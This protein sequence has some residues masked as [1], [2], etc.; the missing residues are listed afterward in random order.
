MNCEKKVAVDSNVYA[1]AFH[2]QYLKPLST[3]NITSVIERSVLGFGRV[4]SSRLHGLLGY[5]PSARLNLIRESDVVLLDRVL[6]RT[7][8]V[9]LSDDLLSD[10][11]DN[12]VFLVEIRTFKGSRLA[13]GKPARG[14]STRTNGRN[15]KLFRFWK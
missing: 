15:A 5:H 3:I 9:I 8:D 6:R 14:Q 1:R 13:R 11:Y 10:V 7:S 4:F 2:Y 12:K